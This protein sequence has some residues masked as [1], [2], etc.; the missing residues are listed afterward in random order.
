[1]TKT[2]GILLL[3]ALFFISCNNAGNKANDEKQNEEVVAEEQAAVCSGIYVDSII[4]NPEAFLG[5]EITICGVATHVCMHE[6]D[7]IF[8]SPDANGEE[9]FIVTTG[10]NMDKFEQDLTNKH[11]MV[12]GTVKKVEEE[13]EVE[14]H[15]DHEV[16]Y[17]LECSKLSECSCHTDAKGCCKGQS[18]KTP[19]K[20]HDN[21]DKP[22]KSENTEDHP[23]KGH[24]HE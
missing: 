24:D 10:E 8:L 19:C 4:E 21:K 13:E 23:C 14:T 7:K 22:C 2:I 6:G 11:I 12:T 16:V 9:S 20:G 5:Q 15:H 17:Y 18:E 3:L 1:M